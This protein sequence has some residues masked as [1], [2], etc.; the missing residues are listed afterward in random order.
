MLD[1]L[2]PDRWQRALAATVNQR[3]ARSRLLLFAALYAAW[4][5]LCLTLWRVGYPP[6]RVAVLGAALVSL[7]L[8]HL[9]GLWADEP[10]AYQR[11]DRRS[12]FAALVAICATGG[13]DS[14][15]LL[16]ITGMFSSYL[17]RQGLTR[18]VRIAFGTLFALAVGLALIPEAWM[19]P[20]M[21]APIHRI[22][23]LVVLLSSLVLNADYMVLMMRTGS[24]ALRALVR[25][26]SE[27]ASEALERAA[28][29]ERMSSRLSHELKNPLSAIK[30][31][32]Q[33]S[34]AAERDPDNRLRLEVVAG[35]VDRMQG[36]IQ[37]YLSFSRPLDALQLS[38]LELAPLVDEVV[39]ILEGRAEAA[40]VALRRRG[41]GAT[42][43][44]P[45][46]LKVAL[47]NLVANAIE[48]SPPGTTVELGIDRLGD[49]LQLT[50]RD[51]GRGMTPEVLERVG[52]PF[53]TTREAGT[54]LG[55][56]IARA[57]IEAH[58]GRLSYE[59]GAERGTVAT[60]TLPHR[61]GEADHGARAAGR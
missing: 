38:A 27:R 16:A 60:V 29:L 1:R 32:V 24:D 56:S 54:G 41:D 23:T 43:G 48:A 18:E 53:F 57:A 6:W 34:V 26:R 7:V 31:L 25:S 10:T 55:V 44:D 17:M 61:T 58:G 11:D 3:W 52:I 9:R 37:G 4:G 50:I 49:A 22:T 47:I 14:P 5:A 42:R 13:L 28:Q 21:P 19:A 20:P 30:A 2:S 46:H 15:L 45:R 8:L 39:A 33:L 12:L 40:Q 36:I 35:E 51:Q 59:S